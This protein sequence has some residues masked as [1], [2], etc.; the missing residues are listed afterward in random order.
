MSEYLYNKNA[1]DIDANVRIVAV[2]MCWA[3][4]GTSPSG[5]IQGIISCTTDKPVNIQHKIVLII[6]ALTGLD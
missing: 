1:I 3:T 4:G 5:G 2:A 6:P